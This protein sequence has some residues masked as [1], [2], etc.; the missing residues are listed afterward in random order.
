[1]KILKSILSL[2][3]GSDADNVPRNSHTR[4]MLGLGRKIYDRRLAV[5]TLKN[6][7]TSGKTLQEKAAA[8]VRLK[9]AQTALRRNK[10]LFEQKRSQN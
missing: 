5:R 8:T 3:F 2:I 6:I 7:A 1:M 10:K 4:T 9:R